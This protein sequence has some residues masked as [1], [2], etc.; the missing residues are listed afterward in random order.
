MYEK[1]CEVNKV[2]QNGVLS[3]KARAQI[4]R[5]VAGV[6]QALASVVNETSYLRFRK[7]QRGAVVSVAAFKP[8]PGCARRHPE[9]TGRSPADSG[10]PVAAT[11]A[12]SLALVGGA[13]LSEESGIPRAGRTHWGQGSNA[14]A[15][16]SGQ[17]LLW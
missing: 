8:L 1:V 4:P 15:D 7:F 5:W 17:Q 6:A 12:G 14:K 9:P 2:R 3:T 16:P 10:T 13:L 11:A